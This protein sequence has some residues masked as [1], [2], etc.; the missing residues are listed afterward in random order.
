MGAWGQGEQQLIQV[1]SRLPVAG[2]VV[3][4]HAVARTRASRSTASD[5]AFA[6]ARANSERDYLGVRSYWKTCTREFP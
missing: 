5:Y 1:H 6:K 3:S 4:L 2:G